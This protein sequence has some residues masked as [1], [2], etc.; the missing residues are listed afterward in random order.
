MKSR[1]RRL[2]V[3]EDREANSDLIYKRPEIPAA[4]EWKE[5]DA[6]I[7]SALRPVAERFDSLE[8]EVMARI[9][10]IKSDQTFLRLDLKTLTRRVPVLDAIAKI[11][12][13]RR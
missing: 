7:L 13:S 10:R 6:R 2:L 12:R 9:L 5:V 11:G 3:P 4:D 8:R 1:G